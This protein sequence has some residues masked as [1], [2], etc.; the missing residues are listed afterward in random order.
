MDYE[1][2]VSRQ[3]QCWDAPTLLS[4]AISQLST[5]HPTPDF[6][7]DPDYC[8]FLVD[9]GFGKDNCP[10]EVREFW[11]NNIRENYM[12]DDGRKRIWM[13]V[14]NLR[15]RDGLHGR[16]KDIRCPVLWLHVRSRFPPL[17]LFLGCCVLLIY[18]FVGTGNQR[19][20][21]FSGQ[22]RARDPTVRQLGRCI[23]CAYRG[24]CTLLGCYAS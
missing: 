13:A 3:L 14:V 24:W 19:R 1:S 21:L 12:G 10:A 4:P 6:Q 18:M 2:S 22:R 17:S 9:T 8:D 15:D 11:R 20:C 16:L 23:T 7:P 5:S